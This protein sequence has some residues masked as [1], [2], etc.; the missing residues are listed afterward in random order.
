M[1]QFPIHTIHI[2]ALTPSDIL[3]LLLSL[4]KTSS[5]TSRICDISN[6]YYPYKNSTSCGI[7]RLA[8]SLPMT[9]THISCM[10]GNLPF[11]LSTQKHLDVI[12][13]DLTVSLIDIQSHFLHIWQSLV[14]TNHTVR[15]LQSIHNIY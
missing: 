14:D 12:F 10:C 1:W 4:P 15:F 9:S 2:Q 13:L 11:M 7:L 8:L 3:R 6:S 5:H